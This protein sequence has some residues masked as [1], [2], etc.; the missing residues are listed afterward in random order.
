[1]EEI[2]NKVKEVILERRSPLAFSDKKVT[3]KD[4]LALIDSARWAS[5]AFNEQPWRFIYAIKQDNEKG[6]EQLADLLVPG[7]RTWAVNASALLLIV[8]KKDFTQNGKHNKHAWYD[9]G[10]AM[11][12][13]SVIAT[14]AGIY[15]HQ[16]AGFDADKANEL[17]D[18]GE[19]YEA[20]A[21]AA[22]GYP[23]NPESLP[24]QLKERER[25][26]RTRKPVSEIAFKGRFTAARQY[27]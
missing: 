15:L 8:A 19:E 25:K 4:L 2:K 10:Q 27:A 21:M 14:A 3:E 11:G 9:T 13:F 16:M 12:T 7:N 1:M 26:P 6:F 17:F 18:L 20:V 23:G 5:S 22:I 24:E